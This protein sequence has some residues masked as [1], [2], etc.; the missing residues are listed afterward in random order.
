MAP[1]YE[2]QNP[3][4]NHIIGVYQPMDS[5]HKF[6]DEDGLEWNRVFSKPQA[7]VSSLS[8]LNPRDAKAFVKATGERKGKLRDIYQLS[9]EMSEKRAAKDGLD[10]VKLKSWDKYEQKRVKTVHPERAKQQIKEK[11]KNKIDI[12]L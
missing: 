3:N 9:A 5:E 12:E 1:Y 6:I 10:H 4:T 7:V 11:F 8:N 2:F